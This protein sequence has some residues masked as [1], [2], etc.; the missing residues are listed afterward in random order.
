LYIFVV[1]REPY[2]KI[3]IIFGVIII[4]IITYSAIFDAEKQNHPLPSF[5]SELSGESS[6]SSGLSRSFSEIVRGNYASAKKLNANGM[7][8]FIFFAVQLILRAIF[9]FVFYFG[10][11]LRGYLVYTD[12]VI[13]VLLFIFCFRPFL[14]YMVEQM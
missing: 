4:L 3:N 14:L 6:V 12:C 2:I 13:S 1:F 7:R 8:I 5:Y 9:S 10:R 11:S